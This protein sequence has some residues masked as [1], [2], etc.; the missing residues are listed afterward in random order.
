MILGWEISST[1]E[2]VEWGASSTWADI[3]TTTDWEREIDHRTKETDRTAEETDLRNGIQTSS[4]NI[5]CIFWFLS[6]SQD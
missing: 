2:A 1:A 6:L 3:E 5:S 4:G